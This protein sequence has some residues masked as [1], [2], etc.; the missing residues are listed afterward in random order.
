MPELPEVE[1]INRG[2]KKYLIG[3]VISKVEVDWFKSLAYDQS[4]IN[5]HLLNAKITSIDRR[6]KVLI[7]SLSNRFNLLFHL[8]MTGQLVYNSSTEKFGAGHPSD[9]LVNNLPDKSTRIIFY[10][11]DKSKLFFNDQRKFGW[12]KILDNQSLKDFEFFNKL[13]PEPLDKDFS[14]KIFKERLNARKNSKIKAVLLDQSTIAGL[15]NIY[16]DE[17]LWMA[18]IHPMEPVYKL[19]DLKIKKLYESI[20]EI[21]N[22]SIQK[23]G[24]S[25]RNYINI[26]G[27]KGS[28]I[29]FANV[30]KRANQD[31]KRCNHKIIRIK[32]ASRGTHICPNCQKLLK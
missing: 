20:I 15:G 3:K 19:S 5:K 31:C 26:E 4:F 29:E 1:T 24:S 32:V 11:K 28:Y 9:S 8:K 18:K 13:G 21:L 27:K 30:Y 23:G 6:G 16:T 25:D 22:L 17:S 14:L 2:M 7:M 12:V 10:F